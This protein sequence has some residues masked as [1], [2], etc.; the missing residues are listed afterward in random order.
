MLEV[1]SHFLRIPLFRQG[2]S[3]INGKRFG[4]VLSEEAAS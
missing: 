2:S 3:S 1:L 4:N